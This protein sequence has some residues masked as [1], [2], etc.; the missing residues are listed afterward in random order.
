MV[1]CGEHRLWGCAAYQLDHLG[2]YP[3]SQS[4]SF[5]SCK[6]RPMSNPHQKA[7]GG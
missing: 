3:A 5:L 7:T 6:L 2:N 1:P 4:L